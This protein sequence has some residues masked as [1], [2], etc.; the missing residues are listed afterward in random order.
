MLFVHEVHRV[1]GA[2]EEEFEAAYRDGWMPVLGKGDDARL[3][4][5]MH[6]A[7][8]S[9]RAYVAVTITAVRDGAAYERLVERVQT[10][11]LR[12]WAAEIDR[13]RHEVAGKLL[14]QVPWSPWAD[15]DLASV[16]T[17]ALDH[18]LTLFME[19]TAWPHEAMLDEYLAAARN[20]Y[21]PSLEESR[22]SGRAL[23]DLQA[24]FQS[25]WGSGR[26][27]EVVLWQKV[28]QPQRIAGLLTTEVPPEYRAPGTWMHDA[29]RVRDDWESRLL[30][31]SRWSPLY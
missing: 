18:P 29:L 14:V 23:L 19:D 30:R 27:R 17:D 31:T 3:L 7:H 21:A 8:G 28:V 6:H 12:E 20:H 24:V 26:R 11:D 9:G 25:A 15:L 22:H 5:F 10:G 1:V 16:P 13:S 4:Y 2:R